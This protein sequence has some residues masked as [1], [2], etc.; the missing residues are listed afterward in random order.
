MSPLT[1]EQGAHR[2]ADEILDRANRVWDRHPLDLA[3]QEAVAWDLRVARNAQEDA[4]P[5]YLRDGLSSIGVSVIA[6]HS[7]IPHV[8]REFV[9]GVVDTV[10]SKQHDYGHENINAFGALGVLVRLSDKVARLRNLERRVEALHEPIVDTKADLLGYAIVG[11]MLI[12]G[13]FQCPLFADVLCGPPP[14]VSASPISEG[15]TSNAGFA[16]VDEAYEHDEEDL[17]GAAVN[18]LSHV[19][20]PWTRDEI[21]EIV[22]SETLGH[23]VAAA[24]EARIREIAVDAYNAEHCAAKSAQVAPRDFPRWSMP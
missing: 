2:A 16:V 22:R 3:L 13:T 5:T 8:R 23:A 12:D 10:I 19:P 6:D 15:E 21:V 14:L 1:W 17:R 4:S 9:D 18:W 11:L 20:I 7:T 24:D